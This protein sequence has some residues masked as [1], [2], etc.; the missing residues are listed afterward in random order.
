MRLT[1]DM[2]QLVPRPAPRST[3]ITAARPRP[4]AAAALLLSVM[5]S[6][7]FAVIALGSV[8]F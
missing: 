8:L 2:T 6:L 5:L 4:T 1:V 7:P 3:P